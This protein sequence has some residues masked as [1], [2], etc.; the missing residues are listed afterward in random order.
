MKLAKKVFVVLM[1]LCCLF[2]HSMIGEAAKELPPGMVIGDSEGMYATSEG[3]YYIDLVDILPGDTFEK[4]ITIRSLDLEEPFSLGML[5]QK[6]KQ[7]G[8]IDW[9]DFITMTLTLDEKEIYQ[10]PLLGN[11]DFDW[12]KTPLALGVCNYGTDKILKVQFKVDSSLTNEHFREDNILTFHWTFIGTKDQPTEPT[13]EPTSDSSTSPTIPSSSSTPTS[14]SSSD[15]SNH[16]RKS[17][18]SGTSGKQYPRTGED[19]RDALYK[20]LV[21]VLLV[22]IVLFLWKKKREE[23]Q[24]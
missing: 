15:P 7:S 11:G 6:E 17:S 4:E 10:G 13:T 1:G 9:N 2:G 20:F 22:L 21:G 5:V 14:P 24:E 3:E 23:E 18:P 12:S 16:P 8:V 19:I